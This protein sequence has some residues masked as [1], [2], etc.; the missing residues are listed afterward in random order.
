VWPEAELWFS[1]HRATLAGA[2]ISLR[3]PLV[4]ASGLLCAYTGGAVRLALPEL[5]TA[6]GRLRAT[7][8]GGLMG[9]SAAEVD[10]LFRALLPRLVAHEIGHALRAEAGLLTDDVRHE[11][12]VADRLGWILS[13]GRFDHGGARAR[14]APVVA[15]LG[16]LAEAASLHRHAALAWDRL[17]LRWTE[18]ERTAAGERLQ[19]DYFRDVDG[20]LRTTVA[21]AFLDLELSPEDNVHAFRRDHLVSRPVPVPALG[22]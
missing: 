3:A 1:A 10:A 5:A 21:W 17:G 20:Y 22:R 16:G 11:E 8:L 19:R 18:A 7:L 12:Q 2:G 4:P 15:R 14:L 9:V 13:R 6:E